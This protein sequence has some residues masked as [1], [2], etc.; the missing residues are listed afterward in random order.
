MQSG[1]ELPKVFSLDQNYP[2]PFNPSTQIQF[3]LPEPVTVTLQLY[4][5]LGQEVATLLNNTLYEPGS[6]VTTWN[7]V[8]FSSGMY[9]YRLTARKQTNGDVVF[10]D[11]KKLLL[12]K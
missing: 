8:N 5:V 7:A 4:N 6:Y 9:F 2:N 10:Q 12:M 3:N 11:V 1:A